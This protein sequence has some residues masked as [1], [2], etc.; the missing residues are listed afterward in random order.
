MMPEIP[1]V[2]ESS[3]RCVSH[4]AVGARNRMIDVNR[5]DFQA[6]NSDMVTCA[7]RLEVQTFDVELQV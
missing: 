1:S 2:D 4:K 3:T 6:A 7:K 5:G